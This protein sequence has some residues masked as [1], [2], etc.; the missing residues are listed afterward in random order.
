MEILLGPITRRINVMY[1]SLLKWTWRHSKLAVEEVSFFS[2]LRV[3]L[4][5]LISIYD[6]IGWSSRR[7]G[8]AWVSCSYGRHNCCH[9]L[10]VKKHHT[11]QETMRNETYVITKVV[12]LPHLE[13]FPLWIQPDLDPDGVSSESQSGSKT[14]LKSRLLVNSWVQLP[15]LM[16]SSNLVIVA[17]L[18]NPKCL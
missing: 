8:L 11:N 4:L 7:Y 9:W 16:I 1:E 6:A 13:D 17:K 10:L 5:Q 18:G 2:S 14:S 12:T 3:V 15:I